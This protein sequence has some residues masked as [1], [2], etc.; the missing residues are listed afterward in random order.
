LILVTGA[1]GFIGLALVR[2]LADGDEP[3][4][5]L[6]RSTTG[7]DVVRSAVP[8]R[9]VEFVHGDLDDHASLRR[10][11]A[12]CELVYHLAG[13]YRGSAEELHRS[14][15]DGT[16][17]L[18][19]ALEPGTRFVY[20]SSTSVYGWRRPWPADESTPPRPDSAYG[21][22]KLAA[23]QQTLAWT[24][25]TGVVVRPTIVYG[26]GDTRGM[27]ARAA[28]LL[29]RGVRRFPGTG[30]NRI[31]LLHVDDAVAGLR[32]VG[33]GGA[34]VY[35]LAG[36][37][38]ATMAR[39]LGLLA[40]GAG[41]PAP[42]FGMPAG[43]LRAAANVVERAW[44]LAHLPGEAPLSLHSV[45]VATEDRAYSTARA[46]AELGWKPR[47]ALEDAMSAVGAWLAGQRTK[48]AAARMGLSEPSADDRF[49]FDWR[50]YLD[51]PDEG[52]GTVF[53][54]FRLDTVLER[55]VERTGATSVLHAP[56]FGMMGIPGLDAVFCARRGLRVG[57]LDTSEERLESVRAMWRDLGLEP[58]VHLV[59]GPDPATWPQ[60]LSVPYDLVFS[61]AALWWYPDPWAVVQAQMRWADRGVLV[62]VPHR[63]VFLKLRASLW[64]RQ[65][66]D[67]LNEEALDPDALVAAAT[68][69]DW[70]RVDTGLFDIPPFPD[71]SVPLAKLLR[72]AGGDG[73]AAWSWSILPYLQGDQP[74]LEQRI[75]KLVAFEER[76]PGVVAP[77]WAHHRYTLL[78]PSAEPAATASA[79]ASAHSS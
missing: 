17:N 74:D 35:L 43:A 19:R 63:N 27:L 26:E 51:D 30:T 46:E 29:E 57:L 32:L 60:R 78:T 61:F 67:H 7:A 5:A 44:R 76:V 24:D 22:A 62:C 39:V 3:V 58:E 28:R 64:H 48:R 33:R 34:G 65:L 1:S 54:R 40:D 56:L 36:P 47:V 20:V 9:T 4:R 13:A 71:T 18:L 6:V 11:V 53:E 72:G 68:T 50:G 25:G 79:G 31:H 49:G 59:D 16:R 21:I 55:A 41:L 38:P 69:G 15:A 14:H 66:F 73:E 8:A 70:Q 12:G 45:A 2:A 23:E 77:R 42:E 10:A 52:L 37:E 75:G